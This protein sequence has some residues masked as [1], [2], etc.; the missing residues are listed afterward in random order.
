MVAGKAETPNPRLPTPSP[1]G[2][3]HGHNTTP[4][5]ILSFLTI[6]RTFHRS[7]PAASN[8]VDVFDL[9][10]Q[11]MA[12]HTQPKSRP[13]R[14]AIVVPIDKDAVAAGEGALST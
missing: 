14:S 4:T 2:S 5:I 13:A 1:S 8:R 12:F 6:S 3:S 10:R 7:H 9:L 11:G